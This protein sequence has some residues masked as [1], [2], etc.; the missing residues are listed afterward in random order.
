MGEDNRE[1]ELDPCLIY[2]DKEGR[3]Y[4][5]GAEMIHRGFIQ[6]FYQNMELDPHGHYIIN[7]NGKRCYV[8]VEDTAFVVRR[9]ELVTGDHK[10][11]KIILYLSDDTTEALKPETLYIGKDDV[12]YCKVKK[13]KF[14]ARFL[15]PAYYQLAERIIEQN[16]NFYL[17]LNNKKYPI[18]YQKDTMN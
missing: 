1:K 4:H 8:D 16:G 2:I 13:G 5:Q 6:L 3:W 15:R 18:H 14:P 11:E 17:P 12:L 10:N 7:W 9:A